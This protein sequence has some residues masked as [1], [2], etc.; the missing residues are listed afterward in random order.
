MSKV[1]IMTWHYYPN[2][3]SALQAYAL[4]TMIRRLGYDVRIINYRNP[5]FGTPHPAK[6][7]VKCLI[8]QVCET[9]GMGVP[10]SIN[11]FL[12]FQDRYMRQ[13]RPLLTMEEYGR[14]I[15]EYDTVV[16]GSDQIWA[17]NVFNP[18]YMGGGL[19][20]T[21]RRPR[22]LVSYAASVGLDTI[23]E[24]KRAQYRRLLATFHAVSLREDEGSALLKAECGIESSVVADPTLLLSCADYRAISRE[25]QGINTPYIF[26]YFLNKNHAYADPIKAY[27]RDRGLKVYGVSAMEDDAAW[28]ELLHNVGPCEFISLIDHAAM[29]F[30][31][32]YHGTIF[33][34]LMHKNLRTIERFSAQDPICQ[35]SRLRQLCRYFHMD[36]LVCHAGDEIVDTG[37]DYGVFETELQRLRTLSMEYLKTALQG[38]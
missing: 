4:Q 22:R 23:P 6:D 9:L 3:G 14:A 37:Y 21:G 13:T 1:G 28:M 38:C 5:K 30:T 7:R 31:D 29:V 17:P 19:P 10:G 11:S 33:S 18:I 20:G 15:R 12:L 32:S 36:G 34:L 8:G 2:F 35:N 27:A 24:D 26:C 16:Y 25:V